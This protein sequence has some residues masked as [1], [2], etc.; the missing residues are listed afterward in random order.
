MLERENRSQLES[1]CHEY[2]QKKT[3]V[4]ISS[5]KQ[6]IGSKGRVVLNR[7]EGTRNELE[8]RSEKGEEGN[9]LIQE[10]LRLFNGKIVEG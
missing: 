2:L 6:E 8:G 5:L 7:G 1:V 4:V 10:A 9:P 3:K